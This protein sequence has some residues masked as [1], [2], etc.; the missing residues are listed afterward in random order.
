MRETPQTDADATGL[1]KPKPVLRK[2]HF[3]QAVLTGLGG[4]VVALATSKR[5][6]GCKSRSM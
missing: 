4:F 1:S 3:A 6:I 5:L 2:R